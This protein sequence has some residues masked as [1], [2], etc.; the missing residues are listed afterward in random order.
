VDTINLLP[1]RISTCQ[2]PLPIE[3]LPEPETLEIPQASASGTRRKRE[4]RRLT[5]VGE[6][7]HESENPSL[8]EMPA[9]KSAAAH[10]PFA[11]NSKVRDLNTN[12]HETMPMDEHEDMASPPLNI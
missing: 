5:T 4:F 12:L 9:K 6:G 11:S 2:T 3:T 10:K 1:D 7:D 8:I